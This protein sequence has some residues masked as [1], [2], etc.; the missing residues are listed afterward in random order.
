M[1]SLNLSDKISRATTDLLEL[2]DRITTEPGIPYLVVG[3]TARD[4]VYHHRFG[5]PIR[6]ATT[7]TD[8]G[9]Q[10]GSWEEFNLLSEALVS[11]NFTRSNSA[12]RFYCPNNSKIDIV[13]FGP[14]EDELANIHWPPSGDF[15]MNVL[16]FK[17]ALD[18]ALQI[19]LGVDSSVQIPVASPQ[20]LV[21]LK[22]IAWEDRPPGMRVRDAQDF[23]YLLEYYDKD[24][25]VMERLYE[26]G[27]AAQYEF[28]VSLASAHLLGA[29]SVAIAREATKQK[30]QEIISSN[31]GAIDEN[32]LVVDMCEH[33][34]IEYEK[35]LE[36]LGAFAEGFRK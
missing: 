31:L 35:H 1:S 33:I 2:I 6:R 18:H 23:A 16:G 10:V 34:E 15:E 5:T 19:E 25:S 14:I 24:E 26:E 20:G 36:L 21:L 7:D 12:H 11:E 22:L 27:V 28:D 30:I 17:E 4:I 9:I 8:F 13:P 3:A 29:D 32:Q